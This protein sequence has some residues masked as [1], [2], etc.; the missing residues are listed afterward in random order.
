MIQFDHC[1]H[2]VLGGQFGQ[3]DCQA[4]GRWCTMVSGTKWYVVPKLPV[5]GV[6]MCTCST[7]TLYFVDY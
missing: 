2:Q 1:L 3:V 7:H 5:V 6:Y 4:T